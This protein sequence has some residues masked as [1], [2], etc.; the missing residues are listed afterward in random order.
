MP[1][2]LLSPATVPEDVCTG[3][4]SRT[5][6]RDCS[7]HLKIGFDCLIEVVDEVGRTIKEIGKGH[8]AWI[9]FVDII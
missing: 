6:T 1:L 5:A 9:P 7:T 8:W 2:F 3:V 4:C